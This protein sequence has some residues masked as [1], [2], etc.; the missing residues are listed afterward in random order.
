MLSKDYVYQTI[1][2]S[3]GG[4]R[5][6]LENKHHY[7]GRY[8]KLTNEDVMKRKKLS[9]N[10]DITNNSI[11]S[12]IFKVIRTTFPTKI[13]GIFLSK[14]KTWFEKMTSFYCLPTV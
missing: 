6:G 13:F 7:N 1:Q 5:L 10:L 9:K 4:S 3:H 14:K 12:E 2:C 11:V 8:Q